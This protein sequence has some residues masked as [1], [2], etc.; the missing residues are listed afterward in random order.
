MKREREDPDCQGSWPKWTP[1][2]P[3][4]P[5]SF[6]SPSLNL[7]LAFS[8]YFISCDSKKDVCSFPNFS[9][10]FFHF[11]SLSFS[12]IEI[13]IPNLYLIN[14]RRLEKGEKPGESDPFVFESLKHPFTNFFVVWGTVTWWRL[15]FSPLERMK[16]RE[17]ERENGTEERGHDWM[18]QEGRKRWKWSVINGPWSVTL[19]ALS[20]SS[21][22]T[23]FSIY[24]ETLHS[25]PFD[26]LV[27]TF[28]LSL[29]LLLS[30]SF[31]QEVRT[32]APSF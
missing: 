9:Q 20:L 4:A 6:L 24:F 31:G 30:L 19:I 2:L 23:T 11:L 8:T 29:L 1:A 7:S 32:A 14:N 27:Q 5:S 16:Q 21:M 13:K 10:F 15:S 12:C 25:K 28:P 26:S 17:R 18:S 3:S 22:P